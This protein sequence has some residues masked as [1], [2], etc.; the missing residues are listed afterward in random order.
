MLKKKNA[1]YVMSAIKLIKHIQIFNKNNATHKMRI[2]V[3]KAVI[4]MKAII[5]KIAMTLKNYIAIN[6]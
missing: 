3:M 2:I 4:Q 6:V 1:L 5:Q